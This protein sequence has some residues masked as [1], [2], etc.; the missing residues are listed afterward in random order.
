MVSFH[1]FLKPG[2]VKRHISGLHKEF[3]KRGYFSKII[4]P[5]R[6]IKENY[7]KDIILLGTSFPLPFGG[8]QGDFCINF[9]PGAVEKVLQREK[10]DVLHF[11]NFGFPSI[12]QIL[13]RSNAL[14]ILTFHANIDKSEVLK[15]FPILVYYIRE[16]TKWKIDGII[17]VASMT[18]EIFKDF[19][20]PKIVIPNGIDLKEFNPKVPSLKK[21]KDN[22]I[23]ILF[24]GRIEKRKGLI[25]LLKAY[26]ILGKRFPNLRLIVVGEGELKKECQNWAKNHNLKEVYFE[27]EVVG[28]ELPSYYKSADVFVSPAPYG[29]SFGMVLL[30]A[31]AC[32]APVVGFA[33]RGYK[34]FLKNKKGE[35]FLAE[36]ENYQNLAEKISI[37]IKNENIRKEM[38][39]WGVKEAQNYSWPKIANQVLDFYNLCQKEKERKKK[40]KKEKIS[41]DKTLNKLYNM[42]ISEILNKIKEGG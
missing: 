6:S 15:N 31:M 36:P 11:H 10:F 16:I 23:N 20:G 34:E 5:R 35:K 17:G 37:L 3:K 32:G 14:N 30:E 27:G 12:F 21:F 13:E 38:G 33:N 24:V 2:G 41:L 39:E 19:P 9:T 25:Y 29:E 1:T 4:A 18:L 26:K 7:G 8:S 42:D 40:I 28:K 22:K